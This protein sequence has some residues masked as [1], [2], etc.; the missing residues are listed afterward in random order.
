M[1][2]GVL[3]DHR[4]RVVYQVFKALTHRLR[5]AIRCGADEGVMA[6]VVNDAGLLRRFGLS[7]STACLYSHEGRRRESLWAL[8]IV[9]E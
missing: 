3:N 2:V 5:A 4:V 7:A 9:R 8:I 6:D 1:Q